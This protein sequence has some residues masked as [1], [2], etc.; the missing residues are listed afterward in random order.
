MD[1]S[2]T[3]RRGQTLM[4]Y[5]VGAVL[6]LDR[7]SFVAAD[8]AAWDLVH[9]QVIPADRLVPLLGPGVD[10]VRMAPSDDTNS[11][12]VPFVRFPRW[13]FC[14]RCRSLT[15]LSADDLTRVPVCDQCKNE[16][17][18]T[19]MRFVLVCG[20]GHLDDVDWFD[21][22]H[23]RAPGAT[24]ACAHR[25]PLR[26]LDDGGGNS[27][28]DA[29]RVMCPA[30]RASRSLEGITGA[31]HPCRGAH[32]WRD[33]RTW[34][35]C[36][37]GEARAVQRGASNLQF[38]T[39]LSALDI[40]PWSDW[41]HRAALATKLANNNRFIDLLGIGEDD[42]FFDD[43]VSRI[44]KETGISRNEVIDEYRNRRGEGG[45]TQRHG[46]AGQLGPAD[47]LRHLRSEEWDALW[48]HRP[49]QHPRDNLLTE[50]ELIPRTG[51]EGDL[52]S[53]L[54]GVVLVSRLREVRA[55]QSFSRFDQEASVPVDLGDGLS[56]RPG[57][58]VFGEGVVVGLDHDRVTQWEARAP[59]K[60]RAEKIDSHR[61][62]SALGT[63]LPE[64]TPRLI[65][66]HTLSHLLMREMA[67]V[68]GYS[69]AALRER[70][71]CDGQSMSGLL[72]YTADGDS[73]GTLGGLVRLGRSDNLLP[74]MAQAL[75][76]ATWCSLDP[77]CSELESQGTDAMSAAACHACALA[78]ET[79]CECRNVLLDRALVVDSDFGF[80]ASEIDSI[81]AGI[82]AET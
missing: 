9:A 77:V 43:D 10:T 44:V 54:S 68:A 20:F 23:S 33:P 34:R 79:S 26:F 59:V 81:R 47:A 4:P 72:I 29:L 60:A 6:D 19:P 14:G 31:T 71:Y 56:W 24:G 27:G 55:L 70:L 80:F 36:P 65:L 30:C 32:P 50:H 45:V 64:A 18:L 57:L 3:I 82:S 66:L 58:E 48:A 73:E 49:D 63:D 42:V 53:A 25:G 41:E 5:G 52:A 13:V 69:G 12:G 2:L 35:S 16:N 62:A 37:S 17:P 46:P 74:L 1:R 61:R 11:K 76:R 15:H 51:D 21:W 7:Q 78:M 40:P 22:A 67:L 8:I 39:I 38:P 28:L 75:S